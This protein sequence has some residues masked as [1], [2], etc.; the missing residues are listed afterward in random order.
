[1]KRFN[2]TTPINTLSY[3]L[4]GLNILK[5]LCNLNYKV[6]L[7]PLG[8][9]EADPDDHELIKDCLKNAQLY[10]RNAPSL[11][12]WHQ[13]D[14]AQYVGRESVAFPIFELNKFTNNEHCHL[15][16]L[17]KLIVCSDWAKNVC[18]A[19][20][21]TRFEPE[22][23][24][25]SETEKLIKKGPEIFI[26]P[27]GVDRSIFHENYAKIWDS[28][29]TIFM[30]VGKWEL[31]KGHDVLIECFNEAFS[32]SDNVELHM[33]C[34]NPFIGEKGNQEWTD[35]YMNSNMGQAGKIKISPQRFENQ[36]DLARIMSKVDCGVFPARAEGWNLD[37]LEML[38]MGK[39]L[40]ITNYSGHTQF[41]NSKNSHLI[42]HEE[43]ME[44]A[45]DGVFFNGQGEWLEFTDDMK[46]SL[47]EKMQ[48]VHKNKKELNIE[49][50]GTAKQFSWQHSVQELLKVYE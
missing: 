27:L 17:D 20:A 35:L 43:K 40:I 26:V 34:Y 37:A 19:N 22:V 24:H 50:I 41:C 49:G 18:L 1:M 14:L 48:K 42:E 44:D 45:I 29:K 21:I 23:N 36:R 6:A 2:L 9:I 47:V 30:N 16:Q 12:I 28:T 4:V 13:F 3:G 46:A 38:S 7:W 31:R 32:E 39:Q 33:H 15:T 11:R 5:Q 10:D 8:G 25:K